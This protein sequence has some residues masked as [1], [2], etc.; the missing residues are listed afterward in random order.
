MEGLEQIQNYRA[1]RK[2][3]KDAVFLRKTALGCINSR[4]TN[5]AFAVA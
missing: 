1:V 5:S 4:Y 2:V 3:V